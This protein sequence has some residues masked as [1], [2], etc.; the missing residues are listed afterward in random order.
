MSGNMVPDGRGNRTGIPLLT[1]I[2]VSVVVAGTAGAIVVTVAGGV[3]EGLWPLLSAGFLAVAG[4]IPGHRGGGGSMLRH[5]AP[6]RSHQ[7]AGAGA[8]ALKDAGRSAPEKGVEGDHGT[9]PPHIPGCIDRECDLFHDLPE[10][11]WYSNERGERTHFNRSWYRFTGI[12]EAAGTPAGWEETIMRE[13]RQRYQDVLHKAYEQ[14]ESFEAEYRLRHAGGTYRWM[15]ERASPR[16]D[17]AGRFAGFVGTAH[18][19]SAQRESDDALREALREKD[20]LLKEVHHRVKNN[21]QIISSLLSLQLQTVPD[22]GVRNALTES[23]NR[24]RS[25]ALIHEQLYQGGSYA[26]IDFGIYV[27]SLIDS[28]R[29]SYI[30]DR[31]AVRMECRSTPVTLG[32][33]TA[34]PLGLIINELVTNAAKYAFPSGAAGNVTVVLERDDPSHLTLTVSDD[35]VG[36]P[37]F[38]DPHHPET[39][40]L[41]LVQ[42]LIDQLDGSMRMVPGR[43][44]T[45]AI[46]FREQSY[47]VR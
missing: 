42:A 45:Y 30:G 39:V 40:G 6:E 46:A 2:A 27:R 19:T 1:E 14:Q 4:G 28:I 36:L 3:V 9:P 41:G 26:T 24:I 5:H 15:S 25:M 11:G 13:D 22:E 38:V 35:G 10:P 33:D 18:D 34:I 44:T 31:E 47:A 23:R 7:G 29:R 17:G 16:F 37:S 20:S 21:L 12:D 8:S 32:L 43:G